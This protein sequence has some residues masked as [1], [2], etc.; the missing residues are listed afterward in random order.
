MTLARQMQALIAVAAE[1]QWVTREVPDCGADEV[2]IRVA[3]AGMN[4]A[5]L[6]QLA[7]HYPPPA[8]ASDVLGLEVSGTV[9]ATGERVTTFAPGDRVCALLVGGGYA[10][11]VNVP[12]GQV[13]AI[14]QGLSLAEAAGICEVYATAWWNL[15]EL[16]AAQPN[17][18]ILVHAGAS[19]VGSAAI[20]LAHNFGNPCFVTVG[21]DE[22]LQW[23]KALGADA[24]WNRQQGSFVPSVK[25]WGGA[26]VILDPVA[27]T[28]LEWNQEVIN[29]DGRIVVI[30]LLAG[31]Y[32][33]LDAGRLLMKR[34]QLRGSTLRSQDPVSKA[35][36]MRNLSQ[37]VWPLFE[38][39][40]LRTTI[41]R[42]Y[43][44]SD[45]GVALEHMQN[46]DTRGKLILTLNSN[47]D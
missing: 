21:S 33:Q 15:Y 39:G 1:P 41:D 30:G 31:R 13:T 18:R 34:T 47:D 17:E 44:R 20:Q 28:Y 27:G 23:C 37:R 42:V 29:L 26:D 10:D 25:A 8:G 4:R 16:A 43:A 36:I 12:V 3:Y 7:G 40:K 22:K 9:V 45:I 35:A 46:N 19:G 14:P 5:D 24:G 32:A 11:Y 2:C 38:A 6:M